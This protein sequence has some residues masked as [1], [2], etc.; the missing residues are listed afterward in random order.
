MAVVIYTNSKE[1][2]DV[3]AGYQLG[4]NTF[5]PKPTDFQSLVEAMGVLTQYWLD[6]AILPTPDSNQV[7][8]QETGRTTFVTA[9]K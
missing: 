1:K 9:H 6:I 4:A 8:N 2:D 7:M 3:L 5:I